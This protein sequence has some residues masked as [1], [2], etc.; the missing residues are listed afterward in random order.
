V[1]GMPPRGVLANVANLSAHER[2][3]VWAIRAWAAN[4]ADLSSVWWSL[5]RAFTQEGIPLALPSFHDT[6]ST[7][8]AGLKRWPDIRCV[9]CP[10]L[11]DDELRLLDL[12][13]SLQQGNE[14]VARSRL[15]DLVLPAAARA[16]CRHATKCAHQAK[17]CGITFECMTDATL[18]S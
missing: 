15:R 2:L 10:H 18:C 9:G 7:L 17:T 13:A 5:D 6:M 14:V 4:H 8:F 11:G 16:V 1:T 3:F 12:L